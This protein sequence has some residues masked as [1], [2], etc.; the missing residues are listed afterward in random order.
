MLCS[1][2]LKQDSN[3]IIIQY[4]FRGDDLLKLMTVSILNHSYENKFEDLYA[5]KQNRFHASQSKVTFF[6]ES[7]L[8]SFNENLAL[9]GL[10]VDTPNGNVLVETQTEPK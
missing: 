5:E 9:S 1:F 7:Y 2:N 6:L 4:V 8:Q 3:T 10:V